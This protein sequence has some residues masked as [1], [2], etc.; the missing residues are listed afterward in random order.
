M[1]RASGWKGGRW[2]GPWDLRSPLG[3]AGVRHYGANGEANET[4]VSVFIES[5]APPPQMLIFGA[6]FLTLAFVNAFGYG[7]LAARAGAM[8]RNPRAIGVFNKVGG[9]LLIGAGVAAATVRT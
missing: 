6:T 5:Y 2:D 4:A 9:S 8:A 7:L 3:R 1:R